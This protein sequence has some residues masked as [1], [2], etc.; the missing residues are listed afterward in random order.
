MKFSSVCSICFAALLVLFT[1]GCADKNSP[2]S[3]EYQTTMDLDAGNFDAVLQSS[4]ATPMQLGAAWFGKAGFSVTDIV[5]ELVRGNTTTSQTDLHLYLTAL[6]KTVSAS[7]FQNLDNAKA[8]YS[9]IGTSSEF[10]KD[11][12]FN[13]SIIDTVK[14]IA[15]V[16]SVIDLNGTGTLSSCD[17]NGN[18]VIDEADALS[19]GLLASG[20]PNP[21]SGTCLVSG[22]TATW[23]AT[24][25]ITFSSATGTYRGLT[26]DIGTSAGSCPGSYQKLLYL[27]SD[28]NYYLATTAGTCTASDGNQWPCPVTSSIDF[29]SAF[30]QSI[31]EAMSA[32]SSSLTTTTANDVQQAISSVKTDACGTDGTCTAAELANYLQTKL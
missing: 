16:K 3:C 6:V 4:C 27:N 29:V 22:Q 25:D 30:D 10:Y 26:V 28:S 5:N 8:Q 7:T 24:V 1:A 13:I 12:L 14:A 21:A 31:N 2:E 32:L 20:S 15:L 11:A 17:I 19:C 23:N 18:S 9:S